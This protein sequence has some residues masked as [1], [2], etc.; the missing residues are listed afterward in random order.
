[1]KGLYNKYI[2]TKTSGKPLADGFYAIVLR[3][4]GGQYVEACR[5]GAVAFSAAVL[6]ENP[7]LAID[8][9]RKVTE[10]RSQ[11]WAFEKKSKQTK[12]NS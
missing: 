9:Q 3:I 12:D 10:L 5:A 2:I 1:M 7:K 11:Q 4:D 6:D 8:I